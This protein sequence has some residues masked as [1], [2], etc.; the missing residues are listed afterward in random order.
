MIASRYPC[1]PVGAP[2]GSFILATL[3]ASLALALLQV[4]PALAAVTGA[5]FSSPSDGAELFYDYDTGAGSVQVD[6]TL[7]G[8]SSGD[9]VDLRCYTPVK[10]LPPLAT[11]IDASSGTVAF[12]ASLFAARGQVCRLALV[13]AGTAPTGDAAKPYEGPVISVSEQRSQSWSGQTYGYFISSGTP[14]WAFAFGS[15]GQC[16][17]RGSF[18]TDLST[19]QY[20]SA[21][22]GDDCLGQAASPPSPSRSALQIDGQNAFLP[23]AVGATFNSQTGALSSPGLTAQPGFIPIS[24]TASF[25]AAH[26]TVAIDD[27]EAPMICDPPAT[28]PPNST[29]C[30]SLHDS[31]VRLKQRTTLLP[32]GQVARVTDTLS[33]VDG[34]PHTIDADFDQQVGDSQFTAA[35]GFEFPNQRSFATHAR[36]DAFSAWQSGPQSIV[37][38]RD[39][40]SS[41]SVSNPVG[42]ITFNRPPTSATFASATGA[43]VAQLLLD[44]VDS[45]PAGGSI[46]YDWSYSQAAG[47]AGL[48]PLEQLERDRMAAPAVTIAHPPNGAVATNSRLLV[49]GTATDNVGVASFTVDGAGVPLT[50]SGAFSTVVR[51]RRGANVITATAS[52]AAGN[53][54]T[55]SATV[56]FD[57]RPQCRVPRLDGVK[58]AAAR[59]ALS[60]THCALGRVRR[61]R[62]RGTH[63]IRRRGRVLSTN[64]RRGSVR[65]PGTRV[66]VTVWS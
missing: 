3:L 18:A 48:A 30:P 34:R 58:L 54:T 19:L 26:D 32:G 38:I 13:P 37:V 49:S 50:P 52:D 20:Y 46:T 36:P 51:L 66:A 59:R 23:G 12:T 7:A 53:S 35:P 60:R 24:Y 27:T 22:A 39:A 6:A 4:D 47:S 56:T 16:A 11:G 42:T 64:P 15:A 33:D 45:L 2:R 14:S 40:T 29:N 21:F 5:S 62:A 63:A 31:G 28:Y 25:D 44:Y 55:A 61:R 43:A 41:P 17:V 65:P 8:A 10:S 1:D 57:P 9:R